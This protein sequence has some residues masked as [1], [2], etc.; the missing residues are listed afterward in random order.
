MTRLHERAG[1][2]IEVVGGGEDMFADLARHFAAAAAL[3]HRDKAVEYAVQA[4]SRAAQ[5]YANESAE[6][7]YRQAL[8]LLGPS[9]DP[10][11]WCDVAI[12]RGEA[13]RRLGDPSHRALMLTVADRAH[14]L[15]DGDR[16]ARALI[17]TYRGTFSR[18]MQVDERYVERLRR[19]VDLIGERDMATR[20]RLLA[21]IG[22]E[23][24]WA[25]NQDDNRL[26]MDEAV[27]VARRLADP[28]LLATVLAHRQWAVFHP[29]AERLADTEELAALC[30]HCRDPL[31]R[32]DAL[33]NDVFTR[34]RAGDREH[35]D[36]AMERLRR[37]A[38]EVD[39]PLVRWMLLIRESA[40]AL[41]EGRFEAAEAY[42]EEGRELGLSTG[43]PDIEAQYIVQRFWLDF[44][45]QPLEQA[46]LLTGSLA[47]SYE[48]LPPMTAWSSIAFRAAELGL[49]ESTRPILEA[50]TR[51]GFGAIPKDQR[52]L[53]TL[54]GL[55]GAAAFLEERTA[56]ESLYALLE[57]HAS[58]HANV[59][60]ATLG[61]VER[62]LGLLCGTL[63]RDEEVE[64]RSR[65]AIA[66]NRSMG[67]VTWL[68]RSQL[69]YIDWRLA[70]GTFDSECRALLRDAASSANDLGLPAVV[71][72][73]EAI[74][75]QI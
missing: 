49:D 37:S 71:E 25:R 56:A 22:V 54:C 35:L 17:T 5:R 13:L 14:A 4:A 44:E 8:H 32:F 2:A 33:G 42:I 30:E 23:T 59:V 21:L 36:L 19:A 41:M 67:T 69:D 38:S 24:A 47:R 61:S 6:A 45:R 40:L 60:F 18:A 53:V 70:R 9:G 10:V 51:Q 68:A 29:L 34:I 64:Y 12:G 15:G 75:K 66:A 1:I 43:Q 73:A 58:E 11:R 50:M 27:S 46:R 3:G 16:M 20:A 26:V 31:L 72:R 57:P 65:R 62:Y 39:Q 74:A 63:G 52:W 28:D 55:A 48:K 7:L